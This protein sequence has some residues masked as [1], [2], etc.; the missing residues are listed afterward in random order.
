M[1]SVFSLVNRAVLVVAGALALGACS[2]A[3]YA[4]LPKSPAY[5]GTKSVAVAPRAATQPTTA[6]ATASESIAPVATPAPAAVAN[7]AP[8]R[9]AV[10]KAAPAVTPAPA[11]A[12]A[13]VAAP[14]PALAATPAAPVAASTSEAAPVAPKLNLVQRLALKK[15]SKK[16]EKIAANSPQLKQR[17]AAASTSRVSGNLRSALIFGVVGLLLTLLGGVAGIFYLLGVILIIIGLVFLLLWV[18]DEA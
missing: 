11:V 1:Q 17:D 16:L 10:A 7:V 14:A 15:I 18:L 9:V 2:R 5:L 4:V 6:A 12:A 3:E 13:P 8:R